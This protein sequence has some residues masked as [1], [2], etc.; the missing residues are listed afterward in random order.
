[1]GGMAMSDDFK[2]LEARL[3]RRKNLDWVDPDLE[4]AANAIATLRAERD[5]A[6]EAERERWANIISDN[7]T[8]GTWWFVERLRNNDFEDFEPKSR[9]TEWR[10]IATA[11][12]DG[13]ICDVW[14]IPTGIS[15]GGYDRV[16]DCWY[17]NGS[18]WRYSEIGDDQCRIEVCN[19][20][21][22]MPLPPAIP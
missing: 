7:L 2:K 17:S 5:T 14:C 20:A 4:A 11:P 16:P 15:G 1:M 9:V 3:R 10:D 12:K 6:R 13:T 22:W 18:W 21:H 8:C 19:V